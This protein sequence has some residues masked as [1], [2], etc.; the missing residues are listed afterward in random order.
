LSVST[1]GFR[2]RGR[3]AVLRGLGSGSTVSRTATDGSR[4]DST[5]SDMSR[6]SLFTWRDGPIEPS[7]RN[8][9]SAKSDAVTVDNSAFAMMFDLKRPMMYS[10]K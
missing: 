10:W 6:H 2:R 7:K 4:E 3:R 9:P 1:V 5:V 8:V